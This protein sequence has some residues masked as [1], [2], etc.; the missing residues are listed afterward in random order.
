MNCSTPSIPQTTTSEQAAA[1]VLLAK[2]IEETVDFLCDPEPDMYLCVE[3]LIEI[4]N[5]L[6][7]RSGARSSTIAEV[8]VAAKEAI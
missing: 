7:S 5:E 1:D 2:I 3:A 4:A 6:R 8:V